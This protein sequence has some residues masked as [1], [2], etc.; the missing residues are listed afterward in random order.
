MLSLQKN[1]SLVQDEIIRTPLEARA[2]LGAGYFLILG[3]KVVGV[4]P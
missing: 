1:E 4:F 2:R 3:H